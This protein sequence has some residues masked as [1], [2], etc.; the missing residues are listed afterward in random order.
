MNPAL[1]YSR[2]IRQKYEQMQA[3]RFLQRP[4]GGVNFETLDNFRIKSAII[5]EDLDGKH[6][7]PFS[8]QG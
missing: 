8:V 7:Q 1:K 4:E 3:E 5:Q 2:D 6:C